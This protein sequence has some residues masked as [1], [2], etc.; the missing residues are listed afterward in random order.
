MLQ[1]FV[2]MRMVAEEC[3]Q[4][5]SRGPTNCNSRSDRRNY[6]ESSVGGFGGGSQGLIGHKLPRGTSS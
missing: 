1:D 4:S 2:R 5:R 3:A 6:G